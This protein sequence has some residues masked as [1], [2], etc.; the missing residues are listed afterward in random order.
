MGSLDSSSFMK[1]NILLIAH[2]ATQ[3]EAC[4]PER[5]KE[6]DMAYSSDEE[7]DALAAG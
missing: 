1:T 7:I 2:A 3:L 4:D 6:L 5:S